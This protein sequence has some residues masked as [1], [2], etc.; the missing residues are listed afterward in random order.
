M[1]NIPIRRGPRAFDSPSMRMKPAFLARLGQRPVSIL[2]RASGGLAAA[3]CSRKPSRLR[4]SARSA[5]QKRSVGRSVGFG[6]T[7]SLFCQFTSALAAGGWRSA[8]VARFGACRNGFKAVAIKASI[9]RR[10]PQVE[11]RLN[12]LLRIAGLRRRRSSLA[13]II[14]RTNLVQGRQA[15]VFRRGGGGRC[16]TQAGLRLGVREK[17]ASLQILGEVFMRL[18]GDDDSRWVIDH[19]DDGGQLVAVDLRRRLPGLRES[20]LLDNADRWLRP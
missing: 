10:S 14:L 8:L 11:R 9:F 6:Y 19:F 5:G 13:P 18:Y 4:R 2:Q 15:R 12:R 7:S 17:V 16:G 3:C 1:A 20:V